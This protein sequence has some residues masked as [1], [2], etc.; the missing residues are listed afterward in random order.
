MAEALGERVTWAE[1]DVEDTAGIERGDYV[2][3]VNNRKVLNGVLE[4]MGL[5][6]DQDKK[7]V[8]AEYRVVDEEKEP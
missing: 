7:T 2:I 3:R 6:E 1:V 5:G 8:D 4:A